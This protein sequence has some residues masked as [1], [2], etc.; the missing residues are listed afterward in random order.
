M[1]RIQH[2]VRGALSAV[3]LGG[4]LSCTSD[5]SAILTPVVNPIFRSYVALGNSIT[6]GFQSDGINDS[7]QS[8]S[9]AVLLARQMSTRF[10]HPS[11]VM[12]GCRPPIASFTTQARVGTGSTSTTCLLR[13][14]ASV[15]QILNNVAVP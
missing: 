10:A 3:V 7:T 2:I 8:R 9:Y 1:F 15:T 5:H 6:A 13:N 11:L 12:P 4:A 14:P